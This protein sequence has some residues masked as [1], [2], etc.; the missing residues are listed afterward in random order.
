MSSAVFFLDIVRG[1]YLAAQF[2]LQGFVSRFH[3]INSEDSVDNYKEKEVIAARVFYVNSVTKQ[4]A[5][6]LK[7][8]LYNAQTWNQVSRGELYEGLVV[9]DASIIH[10]VESVGLYLTLKNGHTAF[11]PRKN[12]GIPPS[13]PLRSHFKVGAVHPCVVTGFN[14]LDEIV[15][16][17]LKSSLIN[18]PYLSYHHLHV[19]QVLDCKI[20]ALVPSGLVVLIGEGIQG[21]LS[22]G[23][24]LVDGM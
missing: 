17:N 13:D 10:V 21:M 24:H 23:L 3:L 19:G 9:Q 12:L 18:Q 20:V 22:F 16:V 6:T 11:A 1:G 5:F 15:L 4:T 2:T 14:D 8:S 7:S